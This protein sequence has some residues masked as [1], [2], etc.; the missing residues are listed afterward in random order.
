MLASAIS[1]RGPKPGNAVSISSTSTTAQDVS[2][3]VRII[4]ICSTDTHIRFG[5]SSVGAATTNDFR[6]AANV[7][8]VFDVFPGSDRFRAI[9]AS[10]DGTLI[11]A[12]VA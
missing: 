3:A 6:L 9:R 11:W 4:V 10:S 12:S 5:D 8:H 7:A 1:I 2:S